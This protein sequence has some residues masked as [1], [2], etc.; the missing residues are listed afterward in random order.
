M[1]LVHRWLLLLLLGLL[2][3]CA[4]HDDPD[5]DPN[6]AAGASSA[7]QISVQPM[8]V[9]SDGTPVELRVVAVGGGL[10]YQW[11]R[12]GQA[13]DG[14]TAAAHY[15]AE[16][17][18]WDVLVRNSLGEVRS[19]VA[20]V[21]VSLDP[22]IL[23]QPQAGELTAGGST[24]LAVVAAG[25]GLGYQWQRDGAAIEGAT[26]PLLQTG[27]PGRYQVVVSS[28][29]SG[30]Q[31]VASEAVELRP[32][33]AAVAPVLLAPPQAQTVI[34]GRTA[35][36]A[37]QAGGTDLQYAWYRN[38]QPIADAVG[39]AWAQPAA[40]GVD[41]GRYH[42]VVRNAA[43]ELSSPA[44]PLAVLRAEPGSNTGAV[45]QAAREL[46]DTLN[47]AQR[48]I[49]PGADASDT[50][51]FN[52]QLAQ[53]RAWSTQPGPH[54]GLRLDSRALSSRQREAAGRLL[55]AALGPVGAQLVDAIRR[56]DDVYA[57]D[58]GAAQAGAG[59]YSLAI[60]GTP[61]G[62][63]PWRL[64]I[65]G[66]QLVMNLAYNGSEPAAATPLVIGARPPHWQ[67]DGRLHEPLQAQRGAAVA[68]LDALQ[69]DASAWSAARLPQPVGELLMAPPQPGDPAYGRVAYPSG[70]SGR[71]V[72]VGQLDARGRA[73]VRQVLHAWV[74][75]QA[76]DVAQTLLQ[77]YLAPAAFEQ[78]YV[79]YAPGR[80]RTGFSARP[81]EE[82]RP[83]DAAGSYLRI[84]G[85]RVWIELLLQSEGGG[86]GPASAPVYLSSVWRDR[87]ADYGARE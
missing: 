68:L 79:A 85:P 86:A 1:T 10:S 52:D 43:G 5:D 16:A 11:Y 72:A 31:A 44:V 23:V 46:L 33:A 49:A 82:A 61:S 69:A 81:N 12:D 47:A 40:A 29:R 19:Q 15:T 48:T 60:F 9:R 7:P 75:T 14:A 35:W 64:Q 65:S 53:V 17:G 3:A 71:G 55:S 63:T 28:S 39:P 67:A 37:V 25:V 59:H 21:T 83:S 58:S 2:A 20:Q 6:D 4:P 66:H 32:A 38:D 24:Q 57:R 8:S 41:E 26:G 84:D 45:V 62:R 13:Q 54:H 18:A 73:A 50:V 36:F 87:Q 51:M 70:S 30:A 77:A 80:A 42:V 78:T 34:A 56:A 76:G 74:G 22:Q 27:T